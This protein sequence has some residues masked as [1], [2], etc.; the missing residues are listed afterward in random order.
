[1]KT[2]ISENA[3]YILKKLNKNNFEAY[4]VG[5]AVRDFLLGKEPGDYDFTTNAKPEDLKKVFADYHLITI[6]QHF[7]TI[8][9]LLDGK[10]YEITTFRQDGEYDDGRKP[11]EVTYGKSLEGDCSRRDFTINGLALDSNGHLYDFFNGQ[12]DLEKKVIRA[13]G[14]PGQRFLEDPLRILRGIRFASILDF[15]ICE[16]TYE[17]MIQKR[18]ELS[19]ISIERI[20][21]ELNK[22]LIGPHPKKGLEILRKTGILKDLLP[23]IQEMVGFDQENP[24]HAYDL[25]YHSLCTLE[26][27][28]PKIHLRLA[29]LFHDTGKIHTKFWDDE[30]NFARYYTHEKK[31]VELAK[32]RM[33]ALKYSK[34]EIEQ[35]LKLIKNHMRV[36][37]DMTKKA[38]KRQIR[39]LGEDLIFDLYDLFIADHFC[40]QPGRDSTF[41]IDT[42]TRIQKILDEKP[43]LNKRDLAIDGKDLLALGI[44]EGPE[45]GRILDELTDWTLE[46]NER[47]TREKLLEKVQ[48]YL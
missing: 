2:K 10:V 48:E 30:V 40:T 29:G 21:E 17:E 25:Y 14:E 19:R 45:I 41:L 43:V 38:L 22:I 5:G 28:P 37:Q 7:G 9:V 3:K 42:K 44:P 6:G 15:E 39:N 46:E 24:Y 12:E 16:K 35:V 27:T 20:R 47:N 33:K 8:G 4:I 1:M 23:E 36:H 31:S 32:K 13:I 34:K 26:K 18:R 11:K